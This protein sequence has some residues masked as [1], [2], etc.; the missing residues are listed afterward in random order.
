MLFVLIQGSLLSTYWVGSSV[1]L[2]KGVLALPSISTYFWHMKKKLGTLMLQ[3]S[4]VEQSIVDK[5]TH[6]ALFVWDV[7][8]QL[9]FVK[10]DNFLHPLFPRGR[11]IGM[12]VHSLWHF[13]ISFA[14]NYPPT[15]NKKDSKIK[16]TETLIHSKSHFCTEVIIAWSFTKFQNPKNT[17]VI[18]KNHFWTSKKGVLKR[19]WVHVFWD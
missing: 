10:W 18:R 11:G 3:Y 2:R 12:N 17:N 6:K 7:V 9:Q 14:G 19:C 13:R 16:K 8:C 5:W 15:G 1:H 4:I